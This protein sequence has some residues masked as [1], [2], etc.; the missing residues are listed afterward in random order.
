MN[1]FLFRLFTILMSL[2]VII[3]YDHIIDLYVLL[4]CLICIVSSYSLFSYA[5]QPYS[6]H[7]VYRVFTVFFFGISP[8][9]QYYENIRFAN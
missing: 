3:S 2:Y 9:L 4:H 6:I 8:V 5:D 7:K 1:V